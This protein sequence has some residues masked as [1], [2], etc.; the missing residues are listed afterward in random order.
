[1]TKAEKL[2]EEVT[3]EILK[4]TSM[5]EKQLWPTN[6]INLLSWKGSGLIAKVAER[7]REE[8][9]KYSSTVMVNGLQAELVFPSRIRD[10][11]WEEEEA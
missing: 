7:T 10:A 4:M 8:C 3:L 11:R 2:A 6:I 9:L 1:M 5:A